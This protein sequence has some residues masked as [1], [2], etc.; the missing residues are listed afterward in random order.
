MQGVMK[1]RRSSK[2]E[3]LE[4]FKEY[5]Q[6]VGYPAKSQRHH[7]DSILRFAYWIK[8]DLSSVARSDIKAYQIHLEHRPN[9]RR[10]GG[11]K[12]NTIIGYLQPL[13]LFYS[14][15]EKHQ[16]IAI[17]PLSGYRMPRK[18][19][20]PKA[21][22]SRLEIEQLY[23]VCE[24][25]QEV[26]ILHLYYGLGLRRM[27]GQRVNLADIDYKNGWLYVPKGKGGKGRKMPLTAK[28][29]KDFKAYVL[30]ERASSK[31]QALLLNSQQNRLRGAVALKVL[32]QLLKRANIP[33]EITLHSLR[34]SIATHLIQSK[35]PLEQVRDYLGHAHLESTQ[36]YIHYESSRSVLKEQLQNQFCKDLP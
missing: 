6:A 18:K 8:K 4:E 15:L 10:E 35:L 20:H 19:N 32:K 28:I 34:H 5:M 29:R 23:Q 1:K 36:R 7:I 13:V 30:E 21:I 3:E 25:L 17:N 33:K 2:K 14:Y 11:L 31:S 22:L 12:V 16:A 24:C 9:E 27:E 26:C